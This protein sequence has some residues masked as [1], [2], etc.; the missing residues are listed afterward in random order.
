MNRSLIATITIPIPDMAL[1]GNSTTHWRRRL[2]PKRAA[3]ETAYLT[4]LASPLKDAMFDKASVHTTFYHTTKRKRDG[5]NFQK[6]LKHTFDGFAIAGVIK[7]DSGFRHYPVEF[8]IDKINPR[9]EIVIEKI[10]GA[11]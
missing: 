3:R 9:V 10:E 4:A 1:S 7:D 5:D 11:V 6:L 2:K 8:K